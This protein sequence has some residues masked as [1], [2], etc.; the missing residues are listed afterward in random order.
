M[1]KT[2]VIVFLLFALFPGYARLFNVTVRVVYENRPV[3]DVKVVVA[4]KGIVKK[5]DRYGQAHFSLPEG[6]YT[7]KVKDN[8]YS[9]EIK[10]HIT[11][12]M[13]ITLFVKKI[14]TLDEVVLTVARAGKTVPVTRT[15][16]NKDELEKKYTVKDV[17]YLLDE[18]PSVVTFSDPGNGV[19]YT[20]LRIRGIGPQ[21]I[22]VTLNGIPLNDPESQSVYWVD[23]PD[24]VSTTRS[25]QVQRGIGTSTYGTG[26][27]GA[28]IHLLTEP[29]ADTAYFGLS[30]A[31]G[32]FNTQ[33][34]SLKGNTGKLNG[35]LG[36][37]ARVSAIHS[38]GFIDRATAD[39]QSYYFS[40][41]YEN[42]HHALQFIHFGG[43]EKTYQAWYG[44]DKETFE[45]NPTFNYAGAI[46]DDQGNITGFY[47]NEV[48][49]YT[50]KH[51]QLH[52]TWH[53]SPKIS[54]QSAGFYVRGYGYY[55]QYKQNQAFDKYGLSPIVI[56]GTV[57]DHTDLIRRKWLDNDF[58]GATINTEARL[59]KTRWTAGMG[60]NRYT[61]LHFGE[62]IWARYASDS[63]IRHRYYEN[64]GIKTTFNVF[65]RNLYRINTR[66]SLY[67]DVQWRNIDYTIQYNKD[68]TFD[69]DE[70]IALTDRLFFLNP[71]AGI[72]YEKDK[73]FLWYFSM[74]RTHREPNRTDYVESSIKPEPE[75]L[76]D[77]ETGIN[78]QHGKFRIQSNL[79]FMYYINQ[80]VYTGRID[81]VGNPVRENVGKSY[82]TGWEN[83]WHYRTRKVYAGVFFTLSRN[84]NIDYRAWDG[85]DFKN[86][87]NTDIAY[88]PSF[89]G[90]I[91]AGWLPLEN[92]DLS[93]LAKHVSR[94]FMDNRNIPQSELPAYTV[95]NFDL[96]YT[97]KNFPGADKADVHFQI[98]NIFNK[99]YAANGYMWGDTP[100]YFPQAGRHFTLS[101]NLLF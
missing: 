10:V 17:P 43:H 31:I 90:G 63:E 37:L 27:F 36:F 73:N 52:Y 99:I 79:Y 88:S 20:G 59:G 77:F 30:T 16:I 13:K 6:V 21:Q 68:K 41:L 23:I 26:A 61:G 32:S 39:M 56:N 75:T 45:K 93:L 14:E 34:L 25:I 35:H 42:G 91:K 97:W 4:E 89:T 67:T 46:Y 66:W 83:S 76:N 82:R 62:I 49:D 54:L 18:I 8:R 100:Y 64:T 53:L 28:N 2:W 71:K 78:W 12:D 44:V 81:D 69:P 38:D 85:N 29:P 70:K 98:N 84:K 22:N 101:L 3:T 48:D 87:G 94:Q 40:S 80:L 65:V 95:V 72:T 55:E 58:Y 92:L 86:F 9:G 24:F 60:L 7:F 19:G 15:D 11:G 47:D 51:Y 74:G 5:T 33:R 96:H 1:K 50:Q 57:I